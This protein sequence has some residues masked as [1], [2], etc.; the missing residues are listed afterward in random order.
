MITRI[1]IAL[2]QGLFGEF[3]GR[4]PAEAWESVVAVTRQAED[5][6]FDSAWMVDHFYGL[7]DVSITEYFPG[8]DALSA[9]AGLAASTKRIRL[10][11]LV[12]CSPLRHPAL[13][14]KM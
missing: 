6:G 11:T 10:G 14:A 13:S 12:L 3:N 9:L 7:R 1:G 8:F 2:P 5:L 4:G